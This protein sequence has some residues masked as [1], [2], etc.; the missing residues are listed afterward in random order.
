MVT[1]RWFK[2]LKISR[3]KLTGGPSDDAH[4]AEWAVLILG[5]V[6]AALSNACGLV[7]EVLCRNPFLFM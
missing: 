1:H 6:R 3:L 7:S 4:L 2:W 5:E